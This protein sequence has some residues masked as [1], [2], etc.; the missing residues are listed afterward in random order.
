MQALSRGDH[1]LLHQILRQMRVTTER[2][3]LPQQP[4]LLPFHDL[5]KSRY[6]PFAGQVKKF[7]RVVSR[8]RSHV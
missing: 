6:I 4:R 8:G 1:R 7:A 3:R 5:R 2:K